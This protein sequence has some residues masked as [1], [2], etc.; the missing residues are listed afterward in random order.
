MF[1]HFDIRRSSSPPFCKED[2][3]KVQDGLTDLSPHTGGKY[4]NGNTS[5]LIT[6][7][8]STVRVNFHSGNTTATQKGF[9]INYLAI[10]P[11]SDN[12]HAEKACDGD[13]LALN[14]SGYKYT[15]NILHA[16]YGSFPY[17]CGQQVSSPSCP[18][19]TSMQCFKSSLIA[20]SQRLPSIGWVGTFDCE[21]S[22]S[23]THDFAVVRS[24]L[25]KP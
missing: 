14:C 19:N 3:V 16:T 9:Q 24:L 8:A 22:E 23:I 10:T 17:T 13:F 5:M 25:W 15:I 4:C 12:I 1:T 21:P 6:A 11:G 7:S 20:R 2:F 18:P